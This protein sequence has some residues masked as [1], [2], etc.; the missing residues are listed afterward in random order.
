VTS[1]DPPK[2]QSPLSEPGNLVPAP[3]GP[4]V[5]EVLAVLRD[6]YGT[7]SPRRTDG[8]LAE[9]ILTILSQNTSDL[10]TDRAFASLWQTFG[11]WEAIVAAP[12]PAIADAIR[13]GGLAEVKAPRI[14]GVLEAIQRDRGSLSLDFLAR[15]PVDDARA[16][17]TSLKGVGPKTAACV[18]LFA[19]GM[20][21]MPVDTHVHRV[22]KRLGLIG[23]KVSA[24]AAHQLL[25][26][27]IPPAQ[28][29]DAHMLL[30]QHGRVLCKALRPR[31]DACP[32]TAGCPKVGLDR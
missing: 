4:T 7:P 5:A 28:M 15:L 14:K 13:S 21:A 29:F 17:L 6:H 2:P 25:E 11:S 19:L 24:E 18:L 20:P 3:S 23:P 22:S 26:T 1:L 9:L 16:Y 27:S 12:V 30:I 8:P 32:L 31:C 10:N